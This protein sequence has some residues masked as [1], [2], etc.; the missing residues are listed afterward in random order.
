VCVRGDGDSENPFNTDTLRRAVQGSSNVG[1][2]ASRRV[3]NTNT[4]DQQVVLIFFIVQ[5][6]A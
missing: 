6:A 1:G 2:I 5:K 4:E 3:F